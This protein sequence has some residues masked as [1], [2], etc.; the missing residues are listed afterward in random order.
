MGRILPE[1]ELDNWSG[2]CDRLLGL[3]SEANR[4]I[5]E[6]QNGNIEAAAQPVQKLEDF[7]TQDGVIRG[8]I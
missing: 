6:I 8:E 1:S 2:E 3:L 7:E 4:L 5:K